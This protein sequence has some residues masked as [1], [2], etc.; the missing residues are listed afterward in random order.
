MNLD[1]FLSR[2]IPLV[3]CTLLFVTAC[4]SN[5]PVTKKIYQ[6]TQ[7]NDTVSNVLVVSLGKLRDKRLVFE[8]MVANK[9]KEKGVKADS[10]LSKL[11]QYAQVNKETIT[12]L[13]RDNSYDSILVINLLESA[14]K[15]EM[16]EKRT[17]LVIER[18]RPEKLTD[19]F[20][21]E[22]KEVDIDKQVNIDTTVS[23]EADVYLRK[24]GQKV[25]SIQTTIYEGK[26]AETIMQN[27]SASI[28]AQ[29]NKDDLL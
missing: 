17:E 5:P 10:A 2:R 11:P 13:V 27:L 29:M 19:V 4:A 22:Y 7:F 23:V 25:W 1:K 26:E 14:I 24:D 28:V 15:I 9:L 3:L 12:N 20:V 6:S 16:D 21:Y 18:P 8:N